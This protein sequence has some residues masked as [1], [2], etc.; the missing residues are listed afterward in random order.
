MAPIAIASRPRDGSA[1]CAAVVATSLTT[2]GSLTL[3]PVGAGVW[4]LRGI[5]SVLG[6][7]TDAGEAIPGVAASHAVKLVTP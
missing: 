6:A 2:T 5:G 4:E 7:V 1:K 3:T